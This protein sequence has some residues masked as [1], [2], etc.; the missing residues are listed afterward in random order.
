MIIFGW[1][2]PD[3]IVS[4][5]LPVIY[6]VGGYL[7]GYKEGEKPRWAELIKSVLIMLA[8]A[9]LITQTQMGWALQLATT[10]VVFFYVDKFINQLLRKYPL[11]LRP[12]AKP[13]MP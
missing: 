1:Q 7:Q 4:L 3:I 9:G 13:A 6:V 10:D 2:V 5:L 11:D 12:D 8:T